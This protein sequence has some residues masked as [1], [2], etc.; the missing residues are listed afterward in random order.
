VEFGLGAWYV[1][2]GIYEIPKA[3]EKLARELDVEF[4]FGAEVEKI[5][6]ENR[7]AVGVKLKED[8][9][10]EGEEFRAEFVISNADAIET[11]RRLIEPKERPS[12]SDKRLEKREPSSSG[13][14]LLLG[15]KK[16]FP[17]LAHH[18]I[19]F[20]DDYPIE[21]RHI[22]RVRIPTPN[23]TVYVCASTKTDPA[24]APEGC[25]NL[26]ILVNAPYTNRQVNWSIEAEPYRDNVIKM[27]E[28]FGLE[29]LNEAIDFEEILTPADFE[30]IFRANR[31]SIYGVSSNGIFS[32]FM[33]I[34][35]KSKDIENLYFVGG[36][37]HPGGGMPLVLLSGKMAADLILKEEFSA[38]S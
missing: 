7:K 13:F 22:F 23:P 18:N 14:V 21:F 32:A 1:K 4:E 36:A 17:Q 20:S 30:E 12:F 19:F 2:G 9:F 10:G 26:F 28:D 6:I 16:R 3:L 24:Q 5:L 37:T 29:G 27:L 25:E 35:N 38:K 11:Y 15:V 34:P 33:R 31:G 8:E